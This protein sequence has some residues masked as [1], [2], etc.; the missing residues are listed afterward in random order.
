MPVNCAY[1]LNFGDNAFAEQVFNN[2]NIPLYQQMENTSH[3]EQVVVTSV[4]DGTLRAVLMRTGSIVVSSVYGD[5]KAIASYL[6]YNQLSDIYVLP[7]ANERYSS[8]KLTTLSLYQSQLPLNYGANKYG[9]FT[10]TQKGDK[11]TIKFR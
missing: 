5:N 10:I 7:R 1:K 2:F 8:G 9:T 4:Y 3:G 11:I 6:D